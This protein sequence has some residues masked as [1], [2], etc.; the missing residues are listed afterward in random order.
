MREVIIG[1]KHDTVE[2]VLDFAIKNEEEA[3]AFY[4]SMAETVSDD[5]VRLELLEFANQERGHAV[6]LRVL[7]DKGDLLKPH[8]K[9]ADLRISN[10][11]VAVEPSP[12]M[13]YQQLLTIAMKKEEMAAELYRD[14]AELSHLEDVKDTFLALA[15]E[16]DKHKLRF[17]TEYDEHVLTEN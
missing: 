8:E 14:L 1:G 3:V 10:Y 6:R 4:S 17:E 13:K 12:G 2:D 16:E 15:E 5:A 9:V 11:L 7:K